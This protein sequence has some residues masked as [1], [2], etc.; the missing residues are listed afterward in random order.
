[1]EAPDRR[2]ISAEADR[3]LADAHRRFRALR[4]RFPLLDFVTRVYIRLRDHRYSRVA[5]GITYYSFVSIFPLLMVATTILAF[6]ISKEERQRLATGALSQVP[7]LGS[8]L[9][10]TTKP[11]NGSITALAL[12]L[13]TALWSGTSCM[14]AI[15]DALND[16]WGIERTAN[17]NVFRKRGRSVVSV[18]VV[19]LGLGVF[20]T[21][22]QLL[23]LLGDQWVLRVLGLFVL[24]G[25]NTAI[26]IVVFQ[27]LIHGRQTWRELRPAALVFSV[28][29]GALQLVGGFYV[30]RV[31]NG[32]GDAYGTF[33]TVLGLLAWLYLIATIL[34]VSTAVAAELHPIV[35]D[36]VFE[37]VDDES[38]HHREAE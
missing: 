37:P 21:T 26:G 15:Q 29:Y 16:L 13:L 25:V 2:S 35:V 8:Q 32:A 22:V 6:V 34:L 31:I 36:E 30:T 11:L 14:A 1:V 18:G 3:Q 38:D 33:A 7:V 24:V 5:A 9:A 19:G 23:S 20:S 10:D 4:D 12:G 28:G 27:V 17:P